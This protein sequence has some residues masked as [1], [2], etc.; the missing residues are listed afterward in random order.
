MRHAH[1]HRRRGGRDRRPTSLVRGVSLMESA[2]TVRQVAER[3]VELGLVDAQ[4]LAQ[5]L[6]PEELDRTL[7][8]F[9]EPDH[10]AVVGL[11]DHLGILYSTD[12]ETFDGACDHGAEV[13]RRELE[14][15][16][17]CGRGLLTITD[18]EVVDVF[19][20]ERFARIYA[21]GD[22]L[23]RFRCNGQPH[24]WPIE[25]GPRE[26]EADAQLTFAT[27]IDGLMPPAGSPARWCSIDPPDPGVGSE[28]VFGDPEALSQ[29][30]AQFGLTFRSEGPRFDGGRTISALLE[31][32]K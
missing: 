10:M 9:G 20:V 15:V 25:H 12:Y 29:L 14:R 18:V 3:I 6:D 5:T 8:Y 26:E 28:S 27:R 31:R 30:G 1:S 32:D 4:T 7:D 17:A 22:H 2:L 24:E 21:E 19:T 11:L 13:Y 16:A 23:L